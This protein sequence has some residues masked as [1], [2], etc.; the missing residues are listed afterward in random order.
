MK[1]LGETVMWLCGGGGGGVRGGVIAFMT[2]TD[3]CRGVNT[4]V[5]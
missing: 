4:M 5:W 3:K 2:E 1:Q